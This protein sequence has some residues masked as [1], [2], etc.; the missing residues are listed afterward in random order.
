[1]TFHPAGLS[2]RSQAS[3][4]GVIDL[5]FAWPSVPGHPV[6]WWR[7]TAPPFTRASAHQAADPAGHSPAIAPLHRADGGA[8]AAIATINGDALMVTSL[9][10]EAHTQLET[11]LS[12]AAEAIA[13]HRSHTDAWGGPRR[14]WCQPQQQGTQQ[15]QPW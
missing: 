8:D 2:Q 7:S 10:A 6:G 4:D 12:A 1:M 14:R 13:T 5:R 11:V 15:D 3:G 9:I